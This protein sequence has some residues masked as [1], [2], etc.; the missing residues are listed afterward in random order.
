MT[1]PTHDDATL[2]DTRVMGVIH[3]IYRRELGLAGG[4]LRGVAP[5]D[6]AR[7]AVVADHLQ[8][9]HDHLHH[10]HTAEDELLWPLLLERVP[11]ELAPLVHLMESQHATVETLLGEVAGLLPTW[12][13]TA[14]PDERDRLAGLHDR[15][16]LHLVE[17]MDAEE[18]RLLPIAARTVSQEEWEAMGAAARAGTPRSQSLLVLGMI[19]QDGDPEVVGLMLSSAPA[20]VRWL[21]PR[22][23]RRRYARH[24]R[25]VHGTATP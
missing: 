22:L 20:P 5:G 15:L 9:V 23:A 16:H 25:A 11:E 21:L 24:A 6:V 7:A 12:R 19:V 18:E 4:V 3:S 1:A 10:H 13:R 14:G 17:H 8:L 2:T